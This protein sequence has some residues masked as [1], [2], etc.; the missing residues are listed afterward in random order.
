MTEACVEVLRRLGKL[1]SA[2]EAFRVEFSYESTGNPNCADVQITIY[3]PAALDRKR[4]HRM[5]YKLGPSCIPDTEYW[6]IAFDLLKDGTLEN[7]LRTSVE[8]SRSRHRQQAD[9]LTSML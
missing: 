8:K 7:R 6:Q 5:R 1:G 4:T 3:F 9:K 2:I